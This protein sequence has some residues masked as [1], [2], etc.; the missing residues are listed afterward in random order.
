MVMEMACGLAVAVCKDLNKAY[1]PPSPVTVLDRCAVEV[2]SNMD[3]HAVQWSS[4]Q[5]SLKLF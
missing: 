5:R 2:M 4:Q 3:M 1:Q